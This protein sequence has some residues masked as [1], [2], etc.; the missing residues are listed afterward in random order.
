MKRLFLITLLL[1]SLLLAQYSIKGTFSPAKDYNF[2][3]LY[4]VNPT[5]S[6][7][8]TNA[9]I[10]EDGSFEFKLDSTNTK[11]TY[12]LVYAVPQEDYNFDIIYNGKEDIELTFNS[13]TGVEFTKSIENKLLTSYTNSMSMV[14]QSIGNYFSQESKDTKA[15]KAIFKTQRETQENFEKAAKGTR[16]LSFIK[17]NKPYV[18]ENI[19][20][21]ETYIN[22]LKDHYFDYVDFNNPIL[23]SSNF[24]EERILNYVFGMSSETK[25][26]VEN[27]K[28]NI[29][30]VY[31]HMKTAPKEVQRILLFDLWQQMA[32]LRQE[33]VSNY[34]SENYLMDI[35]VALNDQ[36]LLQSL[37]L[38]KN[39][40]KGTVAPNFDIEIKEKDKLITKKLTD[41]KGAE[42]YIIVF[43]SSTCSHCLDEVPQLQ[44][45]VNTFEKN[46]VKV[47]AIGLEDEPYGWKNLTYDY[48]EFIHVY[49]EGKWDNKIGDAYGVSST[50]TYFI[51]DKDK[52]I[53]AKPLDFEVLKEFFEP[54][55]EVKEQ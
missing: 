52:K 43:W 11:G 50:P 44:K 8:V 1:P 27:Y 24:L 7:Y 26:E 46:K 32:D 36:Q 12:R 30:V 41:L 53:V 23:Q 13:E 4:K 5:I 51:L 38:Y 17:A 9:A 34:I 47:V 29:D 19:E 21:V 10:G 48:P 55:E 31:G 22:N 54:K 2:A 6:D 40:S 20:D 35:A 3:L 37:I 15:L 14:T 28:E 33:S 45:F 42:N 16:V 49:G 18:P 25:D 39:L